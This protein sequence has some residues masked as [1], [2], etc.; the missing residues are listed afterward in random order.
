MEQWNSRITEKVALPGV[1][2]DEALGIVQ[3]KVGHILRAARTRRRRRPLR[4]D[5]GEGHATDKFQRGRKYIN[6]RTLC[7]TLEEMLEEQ[8]QEVAQ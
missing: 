6:I 4:A 5:R 7:N 1:T 8:A 2:K 3:H